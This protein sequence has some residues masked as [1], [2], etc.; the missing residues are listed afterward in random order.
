MAQG[1]WQGRNVL[2]TGASGFIG[3]HVVQLLVEQGARVTAVTPLIGRGDVAANPRRLDANMTVVHADLTEPDDC[4]AVCRNQDVVM[5]VAHVDGSTGFKRARPAFI[6]RQNL[7]ITLNMLEAACQ[8]AVDRFLVMSSAEVYAPDA[9]VPIPESEG[10]EGVPDPVTDGYAWSKRMSE[11]AAEA[12]AREHGIKVAIARPS[13]VYGPGDHFD[14]SKGRVI[15][16]FMQKVFQGA[17]SILIWGTGDQVRTFLYVEDLARG[18]LDLVEKHPT[19]DPVNFG[20]REEI[21]IRSLAELIVRLSGRDVTIICD[22]DKPAGPRNRALDI[23]KARNLLG[24]V[25]TVPLEVGL[26]RTI[27]AY[28]Q[29]H[30]Y[31]LR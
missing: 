4:L 18:L 3:S 7:L 13:N 17:E 14:A 30:A 16:M 22:P 11:F 29:Q 31:S 9:R 12:F 25:P 6:L 15:P 10:F 5:N 28:R 20:G 21:T 23:T 8:C 2:V 27:D 24:F 19:C 1:Y 26:Q